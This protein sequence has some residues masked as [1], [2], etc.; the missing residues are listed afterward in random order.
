LLKSF[1]HMRR[2]LLILCLVPLLLPAQRLERMGSAINSS[3]APDYYPQISSSGKLFF[4]I[5]FGHPGN[6]TSS[7]EDIWYSEKQADGT[8]SKAKNAG[9]PLNNNN[10][11]GVVSISADENTLYVANTYNA[12]GS[13]KGGGISYSERTA[14]GWSVPKPIII[15]QYYNNSNNLQNFCFS[16]S[17]KQ[18]F[19]SLQRRD[20]RGKVDLYVCFREKEGIYSPPVNLGSDINTPN[21]EFSPFMAADNRTLY[22]SSNRYGGEGKADIYVSRREGDSWK[23]WS[24]PENLGPII[25][26]EGFD[27]FFSVTPNGKHAYFARR[28]D[29]DDDI[30]RVTLNESNTRPDPTVLVQGVV[31]NESTGD[32]L[33]AEIRYYDIETSEEMGLARSSAVDGAYKVLLPAGRR[34]SFRAERKD[35]FPISENLDLKKTVKYGEMKRD[36]RLVPLEK[37][38]EIR[39]NNL[40]FATGKAEL[41]SSSKLELDRLVRFL[42]ENP[43]I[44][45]EINGH[46][47]SQGGLE[48][49]QTLSEDRASAVVVHLLTKGI[50]PDRLNSRGFGESKPVAS[51]TTT[52][53]RA[54]NRR[55]TFRIL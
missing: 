49:N 48:T 5:R 46:T 34:Y 1:S 52:K 50:T 39:L 7:D 23:K 22:F 30:F 42:E 38:S 31:R 35:F 33:A 11:N 21:D 45:I 55:V 32:P 36:L 4:F 17:R 24:T 15:R 19:L 12:D 9:A 8:W 13:F 54:Q 16:P 20:S 44:R 14:D 18:L 47:D 37:G 3:I 6:V 28:I 51:N 25:N 27:A 2:L 26:S 43:D 29:G 41:N 40:F 10:S 53:G